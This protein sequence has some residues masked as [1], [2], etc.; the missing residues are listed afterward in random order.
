SWKSS[1]DEDV[2]SHEE[3]KES[4]ES[5]DDSVKEVIMILMRLSNLVLESRFS[6]EA[7]IQEEEDAE[8]LYRDAN[9][10]Q[11]MGLQVTQSVQDTH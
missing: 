3:G 8:E 6:E 11:G 1:D 5:N 10:N 4:D 9:I 2:G 7:R